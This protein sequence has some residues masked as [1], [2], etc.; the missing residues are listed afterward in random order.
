MNV[1]MTCALAGAVA[2]LVNS[3][4]CGDECAQSRVIELSYTGN[5]SGGTYWRELFLPLN[6]VLGGGASPVIRQGPFPPGF[7]GGGCS[8]EASEQDTAGFAVEFWMDTDGDDVAPCAVMD[9]PGLR[10]RERCRPDPGEPQVLHEFTGRGKGLTHVS[11][12]LR[13]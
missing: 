8:E 2:L 4:G 9:G 10:D 3:S 1:R 12:I 5:K 6:A 7:V 13:D 11:V